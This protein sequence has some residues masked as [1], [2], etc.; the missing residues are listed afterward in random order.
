MTDPASFQ[1]IE[2]YW[3]REA[4]N[5]VGDDAVIMIVGNKSD[6]ENTID[7][8]IID[9]FILDTGL[10]SYKVSAKTGENVE[11]MFIELCQVLVEKE[12][13]M[14]PMKNEKNKKQNKIK[15]GDEEEKKRKR[16]ICCKR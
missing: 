9:H 13:L 3:L 16:D 14:K 6:M 5:N 11:K 4:K 1:E 15:I 2:E 10:S 8:S 7:D 12:K